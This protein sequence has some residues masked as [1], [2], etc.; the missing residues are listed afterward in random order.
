V[1]TQNAFINSCGS[2]QTKE[3]DNAQTAAYSA[4]YGM[5]IISD[6]QF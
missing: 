6:K 5:A 2:S 3:G 4:V 1:F